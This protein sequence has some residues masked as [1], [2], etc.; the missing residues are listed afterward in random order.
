M[1]TIAHQTLV[2]ENGKPEAALIPWNVFVEL[3]ELLGE[4]QPNETTQA[5]MAETT[6]GLPRFG[7][8][9]DLMTDLNS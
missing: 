7:S 3:Q 1:I 8:V 5:A 4:Q 6:K 2:G 9:A